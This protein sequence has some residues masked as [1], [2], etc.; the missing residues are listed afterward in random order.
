LALA[1]TLGLSDAA[2][3]YETLAAQKDPA[4]L[5]PETGVW[6]PAPRARESALAANP[7]IREEP[8]GTTAD[9]PPNDPMSE[10]P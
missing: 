10:V 1:R 9:E 2:A 5:L 6:L 4:T 7:M 3:L 8:A